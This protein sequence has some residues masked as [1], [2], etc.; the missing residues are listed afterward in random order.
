MK[1]ISPIRFRLIVQTTFTLFCIYV[2]F[3][4]A[5]FLAWANGLSNTFVPKPGAVEGFLPISALLGFRRFITTGEW[6]SIHPAGLS[7]FI[8]ALLMAFLFR[9]GFC[10]YVCP[11]GFVSSLLERAGRKL[12]ISTTPPKWI[13]IPLTGIKYLLLGGFCFAIFSMD[14]R[15]LEAFITG[16]YNMVSDAKMLAFFTSPSALSLTVI[17]VLAILSLVVRN[18]WCRYLCPYGALLGLLAWI[19]PTH[20]KRNTT[21]CID[22]GKC[23]A[24]CPAGIKVQDKKVVRSPEC[25]G[26][27]QCIAECPVN[28]CLSLSVAGRKAI[29]WLTVGIGSVALLLLIWAWAKAT[30][31]WDSEM[32]S[33]MLKRIYTMAFGA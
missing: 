10:G 8:A 32:P 26:C 3:R 13:N 1:N 20:V 22:C 21:T 7:I 6:D 18:F 19:G 14:A 29:P 9:K 5:A 4:F 30:G 33:F 17:G 28:D 2:G 16:P 15:S 23:T 12:N 24:H 11:I 27:A 25:I 31:H